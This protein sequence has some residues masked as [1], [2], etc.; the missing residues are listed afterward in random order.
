MK[1]NKVLVVAAHPDDETLG[2]GGVIK[3]LSDKGI[4]CFILF[5]TNGVS[6]REHPRQGIYERQERAKKALKILGGEIVEF[7]EFPDN[8]LDAIPEIEITKFISSYIDIIRPDT[9][10]THS[11]HDLNIDHTIT[12]K[13]TLV[14]CR[15]KT[16]SSVNQVLFFEIV[17]STGWF[18][19][20]SLFNPQIFYNI[21]DNFGFK[22][23]AMNEY[24]NE[25]D[26]APN[27][28]SIE[29]INA[30]ATFRGMTV[31]FNKAESF[32]LGY[33]RD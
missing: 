27:Y 25:I 10:F 24:G 31:G 12:S 21:S 1:I 2:M 16:S 20:S 4:R 14:A 30:L 19:G 5:M 8:S 18:F 13:S 9:V 11:K 15:P 3:N 32:E 22:I 6:S 29:A 33:L 23:E 26:E 28:R 17:S 7:G